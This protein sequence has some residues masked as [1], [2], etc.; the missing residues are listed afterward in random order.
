MDDLKER[1]FETGEANFE[2]I[3]LEV[4]RYQFHQVPV[5]HQFCHLL[6]RTPQNVQQLCDI[7]FL[8]IEFF[9]SQKILAEGS[10]AATVFES[11]GT[12]GS[13]PSKHYVADENLYRQSF[14]RSFERCYGSIQDYVFLSLLP[15]Y[16]ERNHSSLIYMA[17]ELMALTQKE[18]SGFFLEEY[19]E[20]NHR[21]KTLRDQ[22]Q[23]TI[24][25]GVTFALLDFS[26]QFPIAFPELIVMETG[27]MKGRREELTRREVHERL[28]NAF[29]VKK[30]HSEYGMTEL[31]SQAYSKGDGIFQSPPWMKVML[32][33][34]Y[35]PL[36]VQ[37]LGVAGAVNVIDLANLYS[38]AFIATGDAGKV[39][40]DGSFEITGRLDN[41]EVRG[42][43]L[44]VV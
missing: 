17:K 42:C 40:E 30:I 22:G 19:L 44:M 18:E 6:H 28:T 16:L 5:Y 10:E 14:I 23:K 8:P 13:F 32:R 20:L 26:E 36:H 43:N 37:P 3:A 12:T 35:D 38:C 7:P 15:S 1:I 27:G 4:F 31:L 29:G 34:L 24:L 2:T 33:D 11:S 39:Y 41:A 21:L 9:K 25:I